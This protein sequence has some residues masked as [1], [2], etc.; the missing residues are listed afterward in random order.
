[1]KVDKGG[2]AG[3]LGAAIGH[4]DDGCFLQA[5]HVVDILRPV[6]QEWQFRRA[7]IAEHLPDTERPQQLERCVLYAYRWAGGFCRLAGQ[8]Q[9]SSRVRLEESLPSCPGLS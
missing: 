4:A 6:A 9:I 2:V 8:F 7:G 5:Q 1:M 3:G